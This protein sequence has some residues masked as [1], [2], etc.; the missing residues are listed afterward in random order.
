[1]TMTSGDLVNDMLRARLDARASDWLSTT[2]AEIAGGVSD[3]RF[4]SLLSLASRYIPRGALEPTAEERAGAE[5][6]LAGWNP[7][8]WSLLE[9][10]RVALI[11][12]RSDLDTDA[13]ATAVESAFRYAD[14]EAHLRLDEADIA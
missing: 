3:D 13:G 7:E 4:A 11:L 8:R 14:I 5:A 9:T 10:A 2:A 12:A 1:M 6:V